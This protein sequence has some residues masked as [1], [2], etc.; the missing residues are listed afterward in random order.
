[1]G[2]APAVR[3]VQAD[4]HR[5]QQRGGSDNSNDPHGLPHS[6]SRPTHQRDSPRRSVSTGQRVGGDAQLPGRGDGL[7][8]HPAVRGGVEH[9]RRRRRGGPRRQSVRVGDR[10][11]RQRA[12]RAAVAG[13][14]RRRAQRRRRGRQRLGAGGERGRRRGHVP[15]GARS[16]RVA[17]VHR[18]RGADGLVESVQR[19]REA[20]VRGARRERQA[21]GADR[22]GPGGGEGRHALDGEAGHRD[23]PGHQPDPAEVPWHA[24]AEPATGATPDGVAS[25]SSDGFVHRC[26]S[27]PP[28]HGSPARSWTADLDPFSSAT[29]RRRPDGHPGPFSWCVRTSA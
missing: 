5:R 13:G 4:E 11:G 29:T 16:R 12:G 14:G 26:A 20:H 9:L 22:R 2:A 10:V 8:A 19:G 7:V 23:Q 21:P 1:M 27:S 3:A 28:R 24:G 6:P 25:S 15:A 18:L 17:D